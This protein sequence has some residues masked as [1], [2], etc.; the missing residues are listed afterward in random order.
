[1]FSL[2]SRKSDLP[3]NGHCYAYDFCARIVAL[4][5]NIKPGRQKNVPDDAKAP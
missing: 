5:P 1:M 2:C 3:E 4:K